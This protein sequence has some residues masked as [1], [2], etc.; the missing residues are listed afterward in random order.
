VV[1]SGGRG[2]D[3]GG[4]VIAE[5]PRC[6]DEEPIVWLVPRL[7]LVATDQRE[8]TCGDPVGGAGHNWQLW[9]QAESQDLRH[10]RTG[11]ADAASAAG[12]HAESMEVRQLGANGPQVSA[13]GLGTNNFGRK[14][15]ERAAGDV[16][17]A[18]LEAG[19]TFVDTA[20]V[21]GGNGESE[22]ILGRLLGPRREDVLIATKFG[23][24]L[25]DDPG[26]RGASRRWI[27]QAVEGSLERLRTDRI[28][29][30]QVHQPDPE[31]PIEE[32]LRALDD[33]V[34]QGKVRFIG[35]SNFESWRLADAVWTARHLGLSVPVSEQSELHLLARDAERELLPA[36]RHFGV[37]F[38]PYHPLASGFL[39]GKYRDRQSAPAQRGR[40]MGT[41]R[42]TELL[43]AENF[44]L[45]ERLEHFAEGFGKSLVELSLAYL[46]SQPEV[47]SVIA[48]AS[49]PEQVRQNV[50]ASDWRLTPAEMVA[51]RRTFESPAA[52][53]N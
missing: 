23:I 46:L 47:G 7:E 31:T 30:Y 2:N 32:T 5:A 25:D 48:S 35:T 37:G 6:I 17:D 36:C 50:A 34:Q 9:R 18:A 51:L 15:N 3:E 27:T 29:L 4:P 38:I 12:R 14:L 20:D 16:L 21:Y 28:D 45:I 52:N 13:L 24:P 44:E 11:A 1:S 40:I 19:I 53:P 26:H 39:T 10:V 43:T 33:L 8:R 22:R 41:P 42:E 49:D